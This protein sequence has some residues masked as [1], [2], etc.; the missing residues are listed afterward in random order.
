VSQ[1][2]GPS[3]PVTEIALPYLT[4][5]RG[6]V[7]NIHILLRLCCTHTEINLLFSNIE[8]VVI[9]FNDGDDDCYLTEVIV[10]E[11]ATIH[12]PGIVNSHNCRGLGSDS[13]KEYLGDNKGIATWI[14]SQIYNWTR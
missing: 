4:C 1:P 11:E 7:Q 5:L 13:S 14:C 9:S 2:Y 3:R 10:S 8:F 12:T 6:P